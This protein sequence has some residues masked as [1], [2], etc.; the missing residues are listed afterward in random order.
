MKALLFML[1]FLVINTTISQN[2]IQ[3]RNIRLV[4][5]KTSIEATKKIEKYI[6]SVPSY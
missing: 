1:Y 4:Y 3:Q 6:D 5:P 2:L